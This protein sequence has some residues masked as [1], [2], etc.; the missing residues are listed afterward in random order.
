MYK[1]LSTKKIAV[2]S[3]FLENTYFFSEKVYIF[4]YSEKQIFFCKF[5]IVPSERKYYKLSNGII[6]KAQRLLLT[7]LSAKNIGW[8]AIQKMHRRQI[9]QKKIQFQDFLSTQRFI[10]TYYIGELDPSIYFFLPG[11]YLV[12]SENLRFSASGDLC[13]PDPASRRFSELIF[14]N[15]SPG[16]EVKG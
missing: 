13:P 6:K 16:D 1:I 3:V 10:A 2:F 5:L 11:W 14:L 15:S 7:F 12:R 9:I 4:H 8:N